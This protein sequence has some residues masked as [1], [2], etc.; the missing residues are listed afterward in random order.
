MN[1]ICSQRHSSPILTRCPQPP[2]LH[3]ALGACA[4]RQA[5]E[6]CGCPPGTHLPGPPAPCCGAAVWSAPS[7]P[8]GPLAGASLR[9]PAAGVEQGRQRDPRSRASRV[10]RTPTLDGRHVFSAST[11]RNRGRPGVSRRTAPPQ[12]APNP[13]GNGHQGDRNR[14]L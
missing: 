2:A 9:L 11:Q 4:G 7:P 12:P 1:R 8:T 5:V 13:D 6:T 10:G 14:Y 3:R